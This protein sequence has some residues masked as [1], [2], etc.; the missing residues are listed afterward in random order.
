MKALRTRI[1]M[2]L[3]NCVTEFND[4][5]V[6]KIDTDIA[7]KYFNNK[8]FISRWNDKYTLVRIIYKSRRALKVTISEEDAKEIVSRLGLVEN[9][10]G[11]FSSA[12]TF[13]REDCIVA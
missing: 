4:A 6:C 8:S 13:K 2:T 9:P 11:L 7:V 1:K 12:S 3:N 5:G 10:S